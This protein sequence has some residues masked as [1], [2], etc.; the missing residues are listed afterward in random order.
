MTRKEE[1]LEALES[2]PDDTSIE[3]AIERLQLLAA[4]ERATRQIEAGEGISHE[5]AKERLAKWLA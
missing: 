3:E 1:I 2:L 5:Q 4:I